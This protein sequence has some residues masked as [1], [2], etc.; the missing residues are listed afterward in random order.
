ML[1]PQRT[2]TPVGAF[3]TVAAVGLVA[4]LWFVAAAQAQA[5]I[6]FAIEAV[7]TTG[8]TGSGTIAAN[9]DGTESV[10]SV[11]WNKGMTPGST[12]LVEQYHGA[13]CASHDAAPEFTFPSVT[14]DSQ[15]A[16]SAQ[17]VV[18]K[19]FRNWPNRPH[20]LVLHA[21]D[22]ATSPVIACGTIVAQ[23]PTTPTTAA[24]VAT[25]A[26]AAPGTGTGTE[27]ANEY[28]SHTPVLL[29]GATFVVMGA[30]W[31]AT[32]WQRRKGSR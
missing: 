28:G 3:I 12:H 24:T 19:P 4:M 20:F 1:I 2:T 18:K 26:P 23:A 9:A 10:M 7:G 13:S 11:Q 21:T 27:R 5:P 22:A 29:A 14:A 31:W 8:I 15:G 25:P 30:A 16:A 32:T 17:I 6:T